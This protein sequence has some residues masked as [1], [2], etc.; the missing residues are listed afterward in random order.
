[1]AAAAAEASAPRAEPR[2]EA[3]PVVVVDARATPAAAPAPATPAAKGDSDG[4]PQA[5]N[6][7]SEAKPQTVL[8]AAPGAT[9]NT[10]IGDA[11]AL[12][13]RADLED[14]EA[15][16]PTTTDA[17]EPPAPAAPAA[18]ED[19]EAAA[20]E[21]AKP[22]KPVPRNAWPTRSIALAVVVAAAIGAYLRW[23]HVI[24]R[25]VGHWLHR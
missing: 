3:S 22:A 5:P 20:I 18:T 4:K 15:I 14:S 24:G 8:V 17:I 19:K 11:A 21:R 13:P 7:K 2:I 25:V 9:A 16:V 1:M 23:H 6:G 10:D 12:T